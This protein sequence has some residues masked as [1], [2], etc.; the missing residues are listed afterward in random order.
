MTASV[1]TAAPKSSPLCGTPP[2]D[3]RLGRQRH[4]ARARFSSFATA[5]TPSGM[6]MPR[7]TTPPIGSSNAQRR[8]M[9]LRSSSG[10][11]SSMSSGTLSSPENAGLYGVP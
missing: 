9:I 8:A 11:G 5:A 1:L 6:P 3:A 4:V 2:I 7:L 10:I